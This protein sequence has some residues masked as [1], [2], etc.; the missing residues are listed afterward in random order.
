M[1]RKEKQTFI[2]YHSHF[3]FVSPL[4][5]NQ[6]GDLLTAIFA[7]ER[8][9]ELPK[10]D[11]ETNMAFIAIRQDLVRNAESYARK[12]EVNRMNGKLGGR[13]K[14]KTDKETERLLEKPNGY[15]NNPKKPN[16]TLYENEKDKENENEIVSLTKKPFSVPSVDEVAAYC[17]ERGNDIDARKFVDFY[18]ARDWMMGK[19]K[20]RD[21]KAAVRTW[22]K[23][24]WAAK[25]S[26]CDVGAT[27]VKLLPEDQRSHDLD[28]IFKGD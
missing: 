21:W 19:T 16:K 6:R 18:V 2:L 12:C 14:D 5:M 4:S 3:D 27:G 7:H 22:E 15:S 20:M 23:N 26:C 28:D 17:Q 11:K 13:P 1:G 8:G 25:T 24:S 10:L 9:E